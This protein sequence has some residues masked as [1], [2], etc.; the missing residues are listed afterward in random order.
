MNKEKK[1]A[2]N[3]STK[4]KSTKNTK[5]RG[6]KV[7]LSIKNLKDL[8]SVGLTDDEIVMILDISDDVLQKHRK[9]LQEGRASLK[10]S[11]KRKQIE[12]ALEGNTTML[13][14]L[15][16]QYLNQKDKHEQD[17]NYQLN[18]NVVS[19]GDK[20]LEKYDEKNALE[21]HESD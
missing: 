4:R 1:S 18:F 15:G 3:T 5:K 13:V 14:W 8:A 21:I 19:F 11:L 12:L 20:K 10:Q 6:R 17:H 7:E 16:K 2:E 9:K